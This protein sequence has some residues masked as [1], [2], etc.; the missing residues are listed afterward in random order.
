MQINLQYT[1][2]RYSYVATLESQNTTI[3][4]LCF[5]L[6]CMFTFNCNAAKASYVRP[7]ENSM[8]SIRRLSVLIEGN[9]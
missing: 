1:I 8:C 3:I 7:E 4:L 9:E 5:L 6:I 2:C